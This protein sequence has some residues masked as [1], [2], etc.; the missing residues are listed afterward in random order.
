MQLIRRSPH[1]DLGC[2]LLQN[3]SAV[4]LTVDSDEQLLLVPLYVMGATGTAATALTETTNARRSVVW[5]AVVCK[6]DALA[7]FHAGT[8]RPAWWYLHG[9]ELMME[10][11]SSDRINKWTV[12]RS[13]PP[14]TKA[15]YD[16]EFGRI[17]DMTISGL[18]LGSS[19][20]CIECNNIIRVKSGPCSDAD[21]FEQHTKKFSEALSVSCPALGWWPNNDK[22][23]R[24]YRDS[25]LSDLR[26]RIHQQR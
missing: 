23:M 3:L 4:T 20:I 7:C 12:N 6:L 18:T 22:V 5:T 10:R 9:S 25:A 14:G 16:A 8:V 13:K 21:L 17:M 24:C 1:K 2:I 11:L 15:F 26:P 19:D